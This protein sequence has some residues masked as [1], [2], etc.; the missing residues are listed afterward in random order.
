MSILKG[1]PSKT[2][3]MEVK[4][5]A[6]DIFQNQWNP[7]RVRNGAKVL[8]APLKGPQVASY[9]GNNDDMPTFKDFKEWFPELQLTDPKEEYRLKMV[10]DRKKRNKGAP[11][12]KT[13]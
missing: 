3:L 12:K 6:A 9:Y 7:N 8:R 5:L 11:K 10:R 4:K 1:L 2:R 13:S